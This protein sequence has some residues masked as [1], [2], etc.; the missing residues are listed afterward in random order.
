MSVVG[1]FSVTLC[2]TS[3]VGCSEHGQGDVAASGWPLGVDGQ[4]S[5]RD[6]RSESPVAQ[7]AHGVA[8]VSRAGQDLGD[9]GEPA[10][11]P[12]AG[13]PQ[14]GGAEVGDQ[15]PAGGGQRTSGLGEQGDGISAADRVLVAFLGTT[16][17]G[18]RV[19][20]WVSSTFGAR[21]GLILGAGACFVA[22]PWARGRWRVG[23]S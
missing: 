10:R 13:E 22:V 7:V 23:S 19:A 8:R 14:A 12:A 5:V 2:A 3:V 16:P 20:G 6:E 17:R 18:G 21:W 9:D 11:G 4:A 15:D 1:S